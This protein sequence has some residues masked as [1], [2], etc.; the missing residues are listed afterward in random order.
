MS[1]NSINYN[2]KGNKNPKKTGTN[3]QE[4]NSLVNDTKMAKTK[5]ENVTTEHPPIIINPNYKKVDIDPFARDPAENEA[6]FLVN[7]EL[8]NQ[9]NK[10]S[11]NEPM[12]LALTANAPDTSSDTSSND[13]KKLV[14]KSL[15]DMNLRVPIRLQLWLDIEP[16]RFNSRINPQCVYWAHNRG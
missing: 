2:I 10:M 1:E 16:I 15:S 7:P 4:N 14:Y 11:A 6:S 8:Q 12:M 13:M 3:N 5:L 9:N